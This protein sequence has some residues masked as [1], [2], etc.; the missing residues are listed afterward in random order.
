MIINLNLPVKIFINY[1]LID[2][3]IW[4]YNAPY[5]FISGHTQRKNDF[6]RLYKPVTLNGLSNSEKYYLDNFIKNYNKLK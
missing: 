2:D 1:I 6:L 5:P 3:V 4:Y